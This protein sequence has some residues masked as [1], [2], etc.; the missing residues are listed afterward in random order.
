MI[1]SEREYKVTKKAIANFVASLKAQ[2]AAGRDDPGAKASISSAKAQLAELEAQAS[3]WERLRSGGVQEV[4]VR[5]WDDLSKS[6]VKAR[7]AHGLTQ[8]QFADQLGLKKQQIQRW[9]E[10]SYERTEF[11]RVIDVAEALGLSLK[12]SVNLEKP[13]VP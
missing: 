5:S 3:D 12:G 1:K 7:I 2:E 13:S 10:D 8:Q 4:P 11:W 6:L 9:E